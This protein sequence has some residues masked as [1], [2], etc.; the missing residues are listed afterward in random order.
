MKRIYAVA[1]GAQRNGIIES[2]AGAVRANNEYEARGLAVEM[3]QETFKGADLWHSQWAV[4]TLIPKN[5]VIESA[6]ELSE[7]KDKEK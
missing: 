7:G 2:R 3:A 5:W 4:V 6:Q 1:F